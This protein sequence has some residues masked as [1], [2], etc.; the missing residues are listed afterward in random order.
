MKIVSWGLL[1][2]CLLLGNTMAFAASKSELYGNWKAVSG[3]SI[4]LHLKQD[5]RYVYTYKMLTFMGKWSISGN[6][7][8]LTYTVLGRPKKKQST[9]TLKNG[10]MTLRSNEHSTVVLK[11][12]R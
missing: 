6:E 8:T 12:T 11:K 4:Q 7:L 3:P 9:F 10:F 2:A 1:V 5:M